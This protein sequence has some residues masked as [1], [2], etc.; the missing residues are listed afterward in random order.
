M[1]EIARITPKRG[2]HRLRIV[3]I[4]VDTSCDA[5]RNA[6]PALSP[7]GTQYWAYG[8]QSEPS[9]RLRASEGIPRGILVSGG[10]E[11]LAEGAGTEAVLQMLRLG[12]D[13][14]TDTVEPLQHPPATSPGG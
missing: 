14:P 13:V 4:N 10:G 7:P 9:Q 1:N 8:L 11:V 2:P 6:V 12:L 5:M 3:G